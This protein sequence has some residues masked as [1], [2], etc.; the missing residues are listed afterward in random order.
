MQLSQIETLAPPFGPPVNHSRPSSWTRAQKLHLGEVSGVLA[1]E[2]ASG[3]AGGVYHRNAAWYQRGMGATFG[4]VHVAGMHLDRVVDALASALEE[5]GFERLADDEPEGGD[6]RRILLFEDRGFTV[7]ADEDLTMDAG[8]ADTLGRDLSAELETDVVAI[9][10]FHSDT[11]ILARFRAGDEVGRFQVPEDGELDDETGHRRIATKFLADLA[12]TED[13]KKELEQGL[14]GDHTFPEET[15]ALAAARIG[16]P[17]PRAGASTLWNDPPAGLETVKLRFALPEADDEVAAEPRA[18]AWLPP[19]AKAHAIHVVAHGEHATCVGMPLYEHVTVQVEALE[20]ERIDGITVELSGPALDLL[21]LP[22]L[23]GWNPDI[24]PGK[25][26]EIHIVPLADCPATAARAANARAAAARAARFPKVSIA[27]APHPVPGGSSA[28]AMRAWQ[29]ALHERSKNLF[30]FHL[31]G[32][33]REPGRGNLVIRVADGEGR[34]LDATE[35]R[36]M[37][38][39]APAPRMPVL[40]PNAFAVTADAPHGVRRAVT[41]AQQY[42]GNASVGGWLAFDAS[43]AELGAF[44]LESASTLASWLARGRGEDLEISI[45]SAGTHPKMKRRFRDGDRLADFTI[46]TRH[47]ATEAAVDVHV[48]YASRTPDARDG[49]GDSSSVRVRHQPHGTTI[50][51]AATRASFASAGVSKRT[52]PLD[53]SFSIRRPATASA[54]ADLAACIDRIFAQAAEIGACVGGFAAPMGNGSVDRTT[55]YEE[56]VGLHE[57][58]ELEVIRRRPR[59]PGW[60]VIVPRDAKPC[61]A[62]DAE[63]TGHDSTCKKVAAGVLVESAAATPFAMSDREREAVERAIVGAFT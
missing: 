28:A 59:S 4:A 22:E 62:V 19:G 46:V 10:V 57:H 15:V 43:F 55:P 49:G 53:V 37:F 26:T 23:A 35:A 24:G 31:R 33:A 13:A 8:R 51:D 17:H 54:C 50:F 11:A 20:G 29:A 7:V 18:V 6:E 21:D 27:P 16:L 45:T 60:R 2:G 39:V 5:Q 61:D 32:T 34:P 12:I 48:P 44:L 56:L 14:L 63:G 36:I 47:L 3:T 38:D 25:K 41:A 40:P 42:S 30:V 1:G 52:V 9:T 58:E